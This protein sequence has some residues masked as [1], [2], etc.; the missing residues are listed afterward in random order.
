MKTDLAP[1]SESFDVTPPEQ[2]S[3]AQRVR[4]VSDARAPLWVRALFWLQRRRHGA[5][6]EPSRVW[7]RAPKPMRGFLH[8]VA[9]VERRRSPIE[10]ALR[11]LVMVKVSQV[12]ACSF[13]IDLNAAN[14]RQRGVKIEKALAIADHQAS[15]LFSGRERAALDYAVAMTESGTGVDDQTFARVR[16]FFDDDAIV[17]LTALIALQNASSKFN[18]A[19]AIPLPG[20]VPRHG[21][22]VPGGPATANLNRPAPVRLR[23]LEVTATRSRGRSFDAG[24][25]RAGRGRQRDAAVGRHTDAQ[26]PPE[27]VEV[28][29]DRT[30]DRKGRPQAS[31]DVGFDLQLLGISRDNDRIVDFR[32]TICVRPLGGEYDPGQQKSRADPPRQ[33]TPPANMEGS[34]LWGRL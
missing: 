27:R 33:N 6:L 8:F 9:T 21:V 10:P 20:T 19:L 22:S 25:P 15:D 11:S 4:G 26:F 2:Q 7:A 13:C 31:W 5:V 30:I 23:R 18:A 29:V 1:G 34:N 28:D 17:E 24:S 12:N 16:A 32:R 14:L 3:D